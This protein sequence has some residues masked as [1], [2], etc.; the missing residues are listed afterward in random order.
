[1]HLLGYVA[2]SEVGVMQM[3]KIVFYFLYYSGVE[4]F[5]CSF[6]LRLG[7]EITILVR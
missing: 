2:V 1:M 6:G 4:Y 5:F 7:K 3:L